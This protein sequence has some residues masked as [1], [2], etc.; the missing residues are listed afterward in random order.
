MEKIYDEIL[1]DKILAFYYNEGKNLEHAD[2]IIK[3]VRF[4]RKKLNE[5][6]FIENIINLGNQFFENLEFFNNLNSKKNIIPFNNGIYDLTTNT[7]RNGERTDYIEL[8][9]NYP[10]D[11]T[12]SNSDVY[13]FIEQILPDKSIRDY[14]LKRFS[15][16]LNGDIENTNFLFFIGNEGANGKSQL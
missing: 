12:V 14:V 10:Y 16:C 13:T 2:D 1:K 5:L 15:D 9:F 6:S 4:V 3:A 11:N 7:F 8:L